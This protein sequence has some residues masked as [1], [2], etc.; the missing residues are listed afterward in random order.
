VPRADSAELRVATILMRQ[1]RARLPAE[2]APLLQEARA[3]ISAMPPP[4]AMPDL[5]ERRPDC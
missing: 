5:G 1:A 4:G 2:T 3:R